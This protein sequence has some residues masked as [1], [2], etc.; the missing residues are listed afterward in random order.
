VGCTFGEPTAE[1]QQGDIC[2][3]R[4]FPQWKLHE[5]EISGSPG[6]PTT[7]A[8]VHVYSQGANLPVVVCAHDCDVENPRNRRGILVAPVF[9]WPPDLSEA[10]SEL[11][12]ESARL[13][14]G[15]VYDFI[16]LFPIHL[17]SGAWHVADFSAMSSPGPANKV[18]AA[19][20]QTK[21]LEMTDGSRKLFRLKL[22]AFVGREEK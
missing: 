3:A 9:D 10:D 1:L 5:Y 22:G 13:S 18:V 17:P 14:D 19:L 8:L 2:S 21:E 16:N 11:L 4:P 12:R 6:G 7:R 15:E 20:K